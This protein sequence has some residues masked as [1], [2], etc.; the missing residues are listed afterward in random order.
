MIQQD[1]KN[2][3]A[4]VGVVY[5]TSMTRP[6]A[7]LALAALYVAASRREA[8]VDGIA[9][10]G[11]GLDTA[12]FCDL[13]GRFYT[14]T[15][16]APNS[17]S[18]LPIGLPADMQLP[19]DPPMV[20]R[21]VRRT[22][23]DGQPQYARSIRS[24]TDT[25]APDALLRNAVTFSAEAVVVLSAPATWLA[26]ALALPGSAAQYRQR[27]K[28]VVIVEAGDEGKDAPAM[29][30]LVA[31]LPVPAV[32]CGRE[33]GEALS[34]PRARI[35]SALSWAPANPVADAVIAA[36]GTAISLH[37]VAALHY[38]LYPDAG[39]FRVVDGRLVA[40]ASKT[41]ECITRLVELA[42]SKPAPPPAGRGGG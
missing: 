5:N 31:A 29:K 30:A 20:A 39:C 23:P 14:N 13:V 10:T 35:E 33:V 9:V 26:K 38:A 27:V 21:V 25:G 1:A 24:I 15:S 37:D 36:G 3:P 6:D 7:A 8:R 18:A 40:D 28:R 32:V 12:I 4:P 22:R 34:S 42:T 17:N 16:R 41:A 2:G 11:A 19:P